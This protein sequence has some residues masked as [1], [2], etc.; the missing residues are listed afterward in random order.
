MHSKFALVDDD[1]G[2]IGTFNAIS[3]GVWWANETNIIVHD[4]RF[5]AELARVFENDV[6][7]SEPITETWSALRS[8]S[9]RA[10]ERLAARVYLA[11]EGIATRTRRE[12][13]A[14]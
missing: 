9:S 3:P 5:V 6:A 13:T 12:R 14:C 7:Q 1:W 2:T 4:R 8:W 11:A 10:W